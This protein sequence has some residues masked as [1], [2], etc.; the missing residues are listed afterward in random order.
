MVPLATL[1]SQTQILPPLSRAQITR[2]RR[3]DLP[4]WEHLIE[5]QYARIY[6]LH[7]RLVDNPDTAADLTQETFAQAWKAADGFRGKS[8]PET[9]LYGVALQ[10]TRHWRHRA[11]LQHPAE[12]QDLEELLD[13][14]PTAVELAWFRQ[15]RE[16]VYAAVARLPETYRRT[17]A[18]RYF[19][20]VPAVEIA[21]AEGVEAGTVRW[22]LHQALKRLWMLLQPTLGEELEKDESE[23]DGSLR[24]AP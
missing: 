15:R 22:R 4:T 7:L 12:E 14:E 8:R 9:W 16:L 6:N 5:A 18:L 24:I 1:M 10:V 11:G 17:V 3:R 23:T 21:R 20:G 13:P 2:M 19:L